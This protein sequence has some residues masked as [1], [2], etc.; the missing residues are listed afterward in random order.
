MSGLGEYGIKDVGYDNSTLRMSV[1]MKGVVRKSGNVVIF[2]NNSYVAGA[3]HISPQEA[4]SNAA[5][6]FTVKDADLWLD[7]VIIE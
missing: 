2:A 5:Q 1:H 7:E 6:L 4:Y 3:S